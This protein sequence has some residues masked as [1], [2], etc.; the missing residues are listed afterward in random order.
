MRI[1][2]TLLD[3]VP[4]SGAVGQPCWFS[5]DRRRCSISRS[6]LLTMDEWR[7]NERPR[8]VARVEA[9]VGR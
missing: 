4:A 8:W 6:V 3:V 7:S 2:Y 1:V 9:G 5:T